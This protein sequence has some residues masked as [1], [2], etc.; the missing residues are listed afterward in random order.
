MTNALRIRR[1][2]LLI[3]A[4][5]AGAAHYRSERDLA[6]LKISGKGL[7]MLASLTIAEAACDADRRMRAPNYS[8]HRHV[9]LLTA[10]LVESRALTTEI[11]APRREQP[12]DS[13]ALAA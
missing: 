6:G 1:P 9:R 13:G 7:K 5:R 3:Q 10:L 12:R 8:L 11:T 4:A 2:K